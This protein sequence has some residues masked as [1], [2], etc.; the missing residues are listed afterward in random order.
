[1]VPTLRRASMFEHSPQRAP[2]RRG[3]SPKG[4]Q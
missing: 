3:A 1:L 2:R 4:T